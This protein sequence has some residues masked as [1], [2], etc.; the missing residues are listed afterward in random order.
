MAMKM[1]DDD[2]LD[3]IAAIVQEKICKLKSLPED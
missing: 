2:Q 3:A 1:S